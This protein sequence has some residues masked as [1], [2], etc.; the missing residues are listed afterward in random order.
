MDNFESDEI[1]DN[2][3]R[4]R[5]A[6]RN[7]N[8]NDKRKR[9]KSRKGSEISDNEIPNKKQKKNEEL[10]ETDVNM[11]N[12]EIAK[13]ERPQFGT[14][15]RFYPLIQMNQSDDESEQ[16]N[17]VSQS[18][19]ERIDNLKIRIEELNEES[20][21]EESEEG[22][23]NTS[24]LEVLINKFFNAIKDK[25]PDEDNFK[26]LKDVLLKRMVKI[27]DIHDLKD[28]NEE[29]KAT[30]IEKY[31]SCITTL[32]I[33]EFIHERNNLK[34]LISS[35][36]DVDLEE[37]NKLDEIKLRLEN[38]KENKVS[39]E[40]RILSLNIDDINKKIIYDKYKQLSAMH[41][42]SE[43]YA[44][45]K[46]WIDN[47]LLVPYNEIKQIKPDNMPIIKYLTHVKKTLDKN[48]Y[49]MKDAKEELLLILNNKLRDPE[50]FKNTLAFVGSPGTGKTALVIAL[51][52]ALNLPYRQISLGGKHDASYFLGHGYT[53]EGSTWGKIVQILIESKCMNPVIYFDELDKISDTPRGEEIAGILTHL[54]DTTQ[55]SQFHDKYF[56]EINFDLSKCLFI[57]SYNDETKVNSI[58]KDR[59]YRIKTKGYMSKE[60]TV[61]A[62]NYL[63]PKIREQVR[64]NSD[65]I[66]IPNDVIA[67]INDLHCNKEDGVRNLKRCLEII[68]TKLNLYRLMKPGTNLFEGEMSL[69]VEFPFTVT[70]DIV[71]KLI[72]R[73]TDGLET[74]RSLY[75]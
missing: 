69:K 19:E 59:M 22:N 33:D 39:L 67:H 66:I 41:P 60:K 45:L 16:I 64:F 30:L 3:Y 26:I 23:V 38:C 58:L 11:I 63:L 20:R 31:I 9:Q 32:G 2:I 43:I 68:Y 34:K 7:R 47:A 28:A 6:R 72:K 8:R 70:K 65:D 17:N 75:L 55:N 49:G 24:I 52:K 5:K 42:G 1:K 61:I 53:Y 74:W 15:R 46:E 25:Y 10:D 18:D 73:E 35:Y 12:D 50:S 29:E 62:N 48:L 54:T 36:V 27:E 44:K 4:N 71:E 14:R 37:K 13:P 40:K 57:F 56:A 51:C 21:F